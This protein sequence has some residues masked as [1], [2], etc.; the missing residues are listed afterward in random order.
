MDRGGVSTHPASPEWQTL[1]STCMDSKSQ[2][3][4][5]TSD[6]KN[7]TEISQRRGKEKK[8]EAYEFLMKM[9]PGW[10]TVKSMYMYN[11]YLESSYVITLQT[12]MGFGP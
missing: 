7:A 1:K 12:E 9:Y 6:D 4:L 11:P 3:K 2:P 5:K 8:F 10:C